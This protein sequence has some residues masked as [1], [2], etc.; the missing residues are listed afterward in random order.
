MGLVVFLGAHFVPGVR[1]A[2]FG[3]SI[4]AAVLIAVVNATLGLILRILTFPINFLTLG[5]FSFIITVLM[6][7]LVAHWLE[8]FE[9]D[10][11]WSAAIFAI[12][13]ALLKMIFGAFRKASR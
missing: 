8:G 3:T 1:I 7:L 12:V 4:I 10:G 2:G 9:I 13:I 11:F 5:L 6:I